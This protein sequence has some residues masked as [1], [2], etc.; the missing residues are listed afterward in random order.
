MKNGPGY[1]GPFLFKNSTWHHNPSIMKKLKN[2]AL[3]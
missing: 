2:V 1:P 3:S